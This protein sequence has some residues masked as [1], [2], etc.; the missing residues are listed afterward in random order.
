MGTVNITYL[1]ENQSNVNADDFNALAENLQSEINGNLDNSNIASDANIACTKTNGAFVGTNITTTTGDITSNSGDLTLTSGNLSVGGTATVTGASTLTG[2]VSAA[3][4]VAISGTTDMGGRLFMD[5]AASSTPD[6]NSLY[7]G[8]I[9]KA[10]A[11]VEDDGT[12][13][14]G[15]NIASASKTDTGTYV[16]TFDRDFANTNY[17]YAG[18]C[19]NQNYFVQGNNKAT[20]KLVGSLKIVTRDY[21]GTLADNDFSI[22]VIGDQA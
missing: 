22:I 14:D 11:D 2:N 18:A 9:I 6:A 16:V 19:Q 20:D 7:K 8:N 1:N 21:D 3:G 4:N 12:L 17:A 5:I 15:F 10:W 13:N